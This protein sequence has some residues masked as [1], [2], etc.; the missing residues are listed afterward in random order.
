MT[1]ASSELTYAAQAGGIAQVI[2]QKGVRT[3]YEGYDKDCAQWKRCRDVVAGSDA[4][5]AASTEYLP[6]L[7]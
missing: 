4:V 3:T 5:K 6:K 7:S 2:S 1:K